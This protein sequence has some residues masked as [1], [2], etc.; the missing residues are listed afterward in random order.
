MRLALGL[1][2]D[3]S[4]YHGWQTQPHQHTLQDVLE[5]AIVQF[6]GTATASVKT[7]TAGRTDA[8]VHAL[9]QVIHFD[10]D[11]E[12]A[13][14][15]WVRGIN[16]YLPKQ[17][18]VQWAKSV[19]AEFDARFSATERHYVYALYTGPCPAPLLQGRVGYLMLPPGQ[20]L[21]LAA[22]QAAAQYLIGEHDFSSFRS[23]EC[24][25]HT[26]IKTIHA[27]DIQGQGPWVYFQ[28]RGNAFLH[29]MV[30]NLVGTLL[31]V[32]Q[33]KQSPEWVG[34]VLLAKS[35]QAAAPTFMPDGL[36]LAGVRYP[37]HF[38]IPQANLAA[39]VLPAW[40]FAG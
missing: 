40:L 34:E 3:G 32:G 37:A 15:S 7:T 9:G 1:Q 31:A 29:H 16:T 33:G 30:R 25:S 10:A 12:R 35:R 27:L 20:A 8:G 11:V 5:K 21:D 38:A 18:A 4:T 14:W 22:M 24:Q 23:A 17:L 6:I 28:V 26:P 36:Y 39:S 2:Y 19:P 13:D